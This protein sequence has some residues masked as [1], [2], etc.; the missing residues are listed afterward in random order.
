MKV[1][2]FFSSFSLLPCFVSFC[3]HVCLVAQGV[4]QKEGGGVLCRRK[5]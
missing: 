1:L 5:E 4:G 3:Y 2:R